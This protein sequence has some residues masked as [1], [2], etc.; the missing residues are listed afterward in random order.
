MVC[1]GDFVETLAFNPTGDRLAAGG[2]GS[3]VCLWDLRAKAPARTR[4]DLGRHKS[5][6][7]GVAFSP[8]GGTLF[9]AGAD[10]RVRS[11][12]IGREALVAHAR[13]VAPRN[14]KLEEWLQTFPESPYCSTF[15]ELALRPDPSCPS[16]RQRA[17]IW[18]QVGS[19]EALR[20]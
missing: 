2:Y 7:Y 5:A 9:S 19:G 1:Q 12:P 18:Q 8:G 15:P 6:V 3:N 13:G 14:L 17:A 16:A 20:R 10:G 11:H 4:I